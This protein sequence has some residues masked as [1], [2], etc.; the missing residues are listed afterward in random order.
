MREGYPSVSRYIFPSRPKGGKRQPGVESVLD[1]RGQRWMPVAHRDL[2]SS[3]RAWA[4]SMNAIQDASFATQARRRPRIWAIR[5]GE[6]IAP[7]NAEDDGDAVIPR[8]S[9]GWNSTEV[10]L[11]S[12][13]P[14][15]DGEVPTAEAVQKLSPDELAKYI[16]NLFWRPV[17]ALPRRQGAEEPAPG[18]SGRRRPKEHNSKDRATPTDQDIA[19]ACDQGFKQVA[20]DFRHGGLSELNRQLD[21][22]SQPS[23]P[24][25]TRNPVLDQSRERG[26]RAALAFLKKHRGNLN[27]VLGDE[28][29]EQHN[30]CN[31]PD[32]AASS[33]GETT[34]PADDHSSQ[35]PDACQRRL[36]RFREEADQ[37]KGGIKVEEMTSETLKLLCSS[38]QALPDQPSE[39]EP[40]SKTKAL[41]PQPSSVDGSTETV[42]AETSFDWAKAELEEHIQTMIVE[43]TDMDESRRA[44][45]GALENFRDGG[46]KQMLDDLDG[47]Q[48]ECSNADMNLWEPAEGG[49]E[50]QQEDATL[51]EDGTR[52]GQ[53]PQP[54]YFPDLVE[55]M[56]EYENYL[57]LRITD[58]LDKPDDGSPPDSKQLKK[59]KLPAQKSK[60]PA[61][62]KS[63]SPDNS[64]SSAKDKSK[65][66]AQDGSKLPARDESPAPHSD[67]DG[68]SGVSK[69]FTIGL[70][71]LFGVSMPS[72]LAAFSATPT[73][74][75]MLG[76]LAL[77]IGIGPEA[78]TAQ[79]VESTV[80][81]VTDSL[82]EFFQRFASWV[83][84][85][86]RSFGR[87]VQEL[88]RDSSDAVRQTVGE[89]EESI[90]LLGKVKF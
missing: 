17:R 78:G 57:N 59:D 77:G 43:D 84:N 12:I 65:S 29:M 1:P 70:G 53:E 32:T 54:E 85:S 41:P 28:V 35:M 72:G 64:K 2:A 23:S 9:R 13:F 33:S 62:D 6:N 45:L 37:G 48:G 66:S 56:R 88:V 3:V 47:N 89:V 68:G 58:C 79:A 24:W 14:G 44:A 18:P 36:Q 38:P 11:V 19:E 26:R 49:G 5:P 67:D 50:E 83:R 81:K 80:T 86:A 87:G 8:S 16:G 40:P 69:A 10:E 60:S 55:L 73:G 46:T 71:I 52:R 61:Q 27:D 42:D 90:P 15:I 22:K 63:E 7:A 82:T 74:A 51:A 34:G 21:V 4:R 30:P 76:S 25:V 39:G 20:E 31:H 75:G